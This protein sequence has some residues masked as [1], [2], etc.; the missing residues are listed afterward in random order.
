[1]LKATA[2]LSS[3]LCVFLPPFLPSVLFC[4]LFLS[5][6]PLSSS[7]LREIRDDLSPLS[8]FHKRRLASV[9]GK[10][11]VLNV[12]INLYLI[13]CIQ[14]IHSVSSVGLAGLISPSLF[15]HYWLGPTQVKFE[16]S[17]LHLVTV[18]GVMAIQLHSEINRDRLALLT[19]TTHSPLHSN[20][21]R[22][23]LLHYFQPGSC[24]SS[25][26]P[27]SNLSL[28]VCLPHSALFLMFHMHNL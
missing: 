21:S 3:F 27:S 1:M 19:H 9:E 14:Q 11:H 16:K 15:L 2:V 28:A 18:G 4:W 17:E 23:V 8:L 10:G 20:Q 24:F 5:L 13:T 12:L 26:L 7:S 6:R 22:L 25:S